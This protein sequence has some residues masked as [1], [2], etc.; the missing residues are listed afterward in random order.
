MKAVTIK[1]VAALRA[2]VADLQAEGVNC[3]L[4]ENARPRMYYQ[5]QHGTCDY[6]L[7]LQGKYDVGFDKQADGSYVPVFDEHA[8]H[9]ANQIG[10][11]VNVCPMP[12]TAEGRAQHQIGKFMS[13]YAK[14]A[15][16]NAAVADGYCVESSYVDE[17]GSLQLVLAETY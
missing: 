7:K 14:N 4:V 10:A 1:D 15:A 2:A 12:T 3:S 11:D 8:Y 9:V 5:S 17:T 16:I 6:V 13:H